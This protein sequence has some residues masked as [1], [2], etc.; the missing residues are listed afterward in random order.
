MF[1][2]NL[3]E[4]SYEMTFKA[5]TVKIQQSKN[6]Q[7]AWGQAQCVPKTEDGTYV[8]NLGQYKSIKTIWIAFIQLNITIKQCYLIV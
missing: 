1:N 7:G 6:R 3:E 4:K 5:V 8:T 2:T